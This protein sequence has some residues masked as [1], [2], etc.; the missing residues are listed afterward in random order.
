[1]PI[2]KWPL[3]DEDS[4][5]ISIAEIISISLFI[6]NIPLMVS[7]GKSKVTISIPQDN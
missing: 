3:D 7:K 4:S 5:T 2:L 1:M 6:N